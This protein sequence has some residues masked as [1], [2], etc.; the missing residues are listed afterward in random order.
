MVGLRCRIIKSIYCKTIYRKNTRSSY[1]LPQVIAVTLHSLQQDAFQSSAIEGEDFDSFKERMSRENDNFFYWNFILELEMNILSLVRAVRERDFPRYKSMLTI[2]TQYFFALDHHHYSRWTPVQLMDFALLE[3]D[4]PAT[5]KEIAAFFTI[6][7]SSRVNSAIGIDQ[8][9][10]QFNCDVKDVNGGLAFL[11]NAKK[12][13]LLK[14]GCYAPRLRAIVDDLERVCDPKRSPEVTRKHHEDY[15]A[16]QKRFFHECCRVKTTMVHI[17]NPFA[18]KDKLLCYLDSGTVIPLAEDLDK[19]VRSITSL[20]KQQMREYIEN[21][22]S[23]RSIPITTAITKNGLLLASK[24]DKTEKAQ[25]RSTAAAETKLVRELQFGGKERPEQVMA[26]LRSEPF[27]N[28]PSVFCINGKMYSGDKSSFLPRLI[29]VGQRGKPTTMCM[30][31]DLSHV[32]HRVGNKGCGGSFG[33][34]FN[35]ITEDI[36]KV[37][38]DHGASTVCVVSDR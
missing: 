21:C 11:S 2:V 9:L 29:T 28:L 5:Y 10:E 13:C 4:H 37:A 18:W 23:T 6:T 16:F 1:K 17:V 25:T 35:I 19:A 36:I 8:A 26:A 20:G 27:D 3:K 24:I 12:E 7:K 33:G 14:W 32:V 38:G 30:V 22:L 15:A 31:V 34:L